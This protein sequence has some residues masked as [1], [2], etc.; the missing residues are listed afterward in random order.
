MKP[1]SETEMDVKSGTEAD[2]V[3]FWN[4]TRLSEQLKEANI[5]AGVFVPYANEVDRITDIQLKDSKV[6]GGLNTDGPPGIMY[7]VRCMDR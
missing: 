6:T 4:H 3:P 1:L 5:Q 7:L 2:V